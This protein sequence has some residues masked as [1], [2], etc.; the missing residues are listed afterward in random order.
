MKGDKTAFIAHSGVAI[1]FNRFFDK[2]TKTDMVSVRVN[3]TDGGVSTK[4]VTVAD[5]YAELEDAHRL[6]ELLT[7]L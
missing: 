4:W 6:G 5:F 1:F 3:K 2:E 7:K